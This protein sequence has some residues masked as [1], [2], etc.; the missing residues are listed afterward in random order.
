VSRRGNDLLDLLKAQ[1][2]A[3]DA[4]AAA[5]RSLAGGA[6]ASAE[7]GADSALVTFHEAM[8]TANG[9]LDNLR[10]HEREERAEKQR[11]EH[12]SAQK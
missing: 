1:E 12:G 3:L 8:G 4:L 5:I 11:R 6:T 2:V 10:E 7:Q 9:C